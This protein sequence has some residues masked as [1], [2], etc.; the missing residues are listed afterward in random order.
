MKNWMKKFVIVLLAVLL[1]PA[2]VQAINGPISSA[3]SQDGGIGNSSHYLDEVPNISMDPKVKQIIYPLFST[4]SVSKKGELLTI[5]IDSQGKEAAGWSIKLKQT[6]NSSLTT[7]Y[8]LPVQKVSSGQSHWKKSSTIYDVTVKIPNDVPEK[9]YDLEVSY[10]GN[11][12]RIT[13]DQPHS[14]KVVN[15]FKKDFTFMHVT[16]TH[17]GSPRNLGDHGDPAATEPAQLIEAGLW[18][19]DPEKRWLYL[20]KAIKEVNLMNPD[21]VV[22]TGDLMF[23]Q[24]NPQEYIYEY[25]E[26]YKF[27]QKLNVPVYL[28]PGNH[29]YYAQD[30]TLADGAKYWEQ[31]FGPQYFSFNYGP[32]AH[33]IGY[34]SFDWHKFDRSGHGT[35]SVPTWGGQIREEQLNWIKQDL[36]DNEKN[37]QAGQVRGLFSHHNPLW[38]DREIWPHDDAEVQEYWKQYDGQHNPQRLDT[39]MLGEKLGLKYDQQWHGENAIELID[40]MQQHKVNI[41]LHGHT[42]VDNVTEKDGVLYTTTASVELSGKPWVGFRNFKMR[43][44][45]FTSYNYEEP[46]RSIPIY[47]NG[48]TKS[49]IMSFEA[50]YKAAN[51]GHSTSQEATVTNRLNKPLT[52]TVPF[53]MAAGDYRI[54]SGKLKQNY[55]AD[56]KQ[57]IEVEVTVP[58]G[59]EQK[60]TVQK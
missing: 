49:G 18:N 43:K 12:K 2:A 30:A 8:E 29:D 25:E 31:Y 7:E 58:A 46:G 50:N 55:S 42:H 60:I 3:G 11:G 59:S 28:V 45:Q 16:D 48:E 19:P 54:S 36:A 22:V 27:L 1:L 35:L 21:F 33:F 20:Q 57:Y 56:G 13:D 24:M 53:Y 38:Q 51:D 34:N 37:A 6:N 39:L 17:V 4:P 26:T 41:S 40:V 14:V 15:E 5:K 9:L 47:M 10:T 44:G 23:G 32:Y 52:V